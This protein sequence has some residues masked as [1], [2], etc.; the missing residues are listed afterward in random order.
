MAIFVLV[1]GAWQSAATWDRLK[2]LLAAAG[3]SV[4]TP[5]LT[6]LGSDQPRLTPEISLRTHIDDIAKVLTAAPKPVI[7]VGHS[8]AGMIVTGAAAAS[9]ER[10]HSLVYIDAF[11][12]ENRQSVLDLLPPSI[13]NTFRKTANA[14]GG[15]RL[16]GG[17]PQL[18]LWGLPPGDAR[19]F[20]RQR[21]C[22]FTIRCFEDPIQLP[23]GRPA[24]LPSHYIACTSPSYPARPFFAPFAEKARAAGWNVTDIVSGHDCHVEQPALVMDAL[25][26]VVNRP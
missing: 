13:V 3:H 2:P 1:H 7:L 19:D 12:P 21:L 9:P 8:Y 25:L 22:D 5:I 20:V 16:P 23:T 24:Q 11:I 18:D 4:I 15:W 6:G 10:V 14:N 17:E 26:R